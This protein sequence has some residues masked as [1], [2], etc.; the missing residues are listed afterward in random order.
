M[1]LFRN[2]ISVSSQVVQFLT[3]LCILSEKQYGFTAYLIRW[4][5]LFHY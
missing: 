4:R 5:Y 1:Q 3:L 2:Y